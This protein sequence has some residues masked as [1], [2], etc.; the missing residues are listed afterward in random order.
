MIYFCETEGF[1]GYLWRFSL[2]IG[3]YI[4]TVQYI[5]AIRRCK[6]LSK[7]I[8]EYRKT[9][10]EEYYSSMRKKIYEMLDNRCNNPFCHVVGGETDERCLVVV[11]VLLDK[12]KTR[13]KSLYDLYK[14]ILNNPDMY[15]LLC[16]NCRAIREYEYEKNVVQKSEQVKPAGKVALKE[17]LERDVKEEDEEYVKQDEEWVDEEF[18]LDLDIVVENLLDNYL[19]GDSKAVGKKLDEFVV[20]GQIKAGQKAEV[21][22]R[23][24]R[25][26][27]KL[28]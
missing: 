18:T 6:N 16:Y 28:V 20:D 17:P 3:F 26:K 15:E 21:M 13:R 23:L 12:T 2:P 22:K 19:A 7:K 10:Y 8:K 25:K 14:H 27:A 24:K 5:S 9:Y 4:T 1:L 11:P